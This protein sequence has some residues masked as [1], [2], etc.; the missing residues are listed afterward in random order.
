MNDYPEHAAEIVRL[1]AAHPTLGRDKLKPLLDRYCRQAGLRPV[2]VSTVGRIV[3]ALK[4]Q[5][6]LPAGRKLSYHA[7][8]GRMHPLSV[9]PDCTN[10]VGVSLTPQHLAISCK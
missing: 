6:R 1:K 5:G 3:A 7:R 10:D 2:S 9:V 8:T 4:F